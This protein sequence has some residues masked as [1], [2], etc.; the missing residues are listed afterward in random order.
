ME[1]RELRHD[2]HTVSL[3]TD[4]M[5]ITPKY[6]E[7]I[8]VGDV[9]LAVEGIIRTTC[10]EMKIE[11]IDM[12]VN[13]DHVH[14]F[15]GYPP[16]YSVS[17]IAKKIKG[18]SSRI[19]RQNFPHLKEWCKDHLWAPGCYHGSVGHGWEVVEKYI[20]TQDYARKDKSLCTS[21]V[22]KCGV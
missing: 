11:I 12:A 19:L 16:K 13:I 5:V 14:L 4:H 9:A 22:L 21:P 7:K 6:R 17:F 20:G 3:L 18:R 1:Q 15:I 8:L 10:K 2:R